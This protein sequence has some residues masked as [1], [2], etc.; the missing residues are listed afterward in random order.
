MAKAAN[1]VLIRC[2]A[3]L[4]KRPKPDDS[5]RNRLEA[6]TGDQ[7]RLMTGIRCTLVTLFAA[8][9]TNELTNGSTALARLIGIGMCLSNE[10]T[11][12]KNQPS[13]CPQEN[14]RSVERETLVLH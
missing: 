8:C 9:C 5:R 2:K 1:G 6:I 4:R 11:V 10:L 13:I 3:D 12:V 7:P 14:D